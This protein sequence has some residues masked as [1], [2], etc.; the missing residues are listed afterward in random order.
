M[1]TTN[2]VIVTSTRTWSDCNRCDGDT[3]TSIAANAPARIWKSN[4]TVN[5]AAA[6]A[7]EDLAR[8]GIR[9]TAIACIRDGGTGTAQVEMVERVQEITAKL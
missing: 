1:S 2:A 5:N 4:H 3:A 6:T 8:F 7:A 9:Q